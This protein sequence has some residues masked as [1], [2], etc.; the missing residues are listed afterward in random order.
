MIDTFSLIVMILDTTR[1]SSEE[2]E[3]CLLS[4]P[5][6]AVET[7]CDTAVAETF[8]WCLVDGGY[9][10][11][12]ICDDNYDASHFII[13]LSIRGDITGPCWKLFIVTL[14][15]ILTLPDVCLWVQTTPSIHYTTTTFSVTYTFHISATTTILAIILMGDF[16]FDV[17]AAGLGVLLWW[18]NYTACTCTVRD[19]ATFL[20]LPYLPLM[21]P[22][23]PPILLLPHSH[24]PH[25]FDVTCTMPARWCTAYSEWVQVFLLCT[26]QYLSFCIGLWCLLP[27]PEY[28]GGAFVIHIWPDEW[29]HPDHSCHFFCS[30]DI[31]VNM[32]WAL[33]FHVTITAW[34][35]VT[36][37]VY[38]Q[39]QTGIYDAYSTMEEWWL[40]MRYC[41]V[42]AYRW[43]YY[44]S[45][46]DNVQLTVWAVLTYQYSTYTN[47]CHMLC[48]YT[49]LNTA[50]T[51]GDH[52]R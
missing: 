33:L 24:A 45:F 40:T 32:M 12:T 28:D 8:C 11:C 18:K 52:C 47:R 44:D 43:Y 34:Y 48:H 49:V 51:C 41:C 5:V 21:P 7:V 4:L 13:I 16:I 10:P 42:V 29:L 36:Y 39:H 31:S 38:A 2:E 26:R 20:P 3:S 17:P 6:T 22:P 19:D 9:L 46:G 37:G 35:R 1:C 23:P 15:R 25:A 50:M 14:I 27:V 30:P